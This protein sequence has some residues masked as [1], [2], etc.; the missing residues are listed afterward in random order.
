MKVAVVVLNWNG[1]H[2][3]HECLPALYRQ[4]RPPDQ[5]IVVDN[6]STDDSVA[7]LHS[8]YPQVE[9]VALKENRGFAG[10]NAVALRHVRGDAVV[11]LNNDTRP[12]DNFVEALV[13]CAEKHPEAG[14]IA[15]HLVDWDGKFT[16]S[17]G[18]GCKV[19][20]RGFARNRRKDAASAPA[21][22]RV[23]CACAGA[24]LYR[25]EMIEQIG[26]L[27]TD[28][29]LNFEDTDLALRACLQ[30]WESWFCAEA[31][32]R[33][34]I[35]ASQGAW[36]R[37]NVYYGAR[38][39]LWVCFKNFPAAVL[40]KYSPLIAAEIL[41]MYLVSV[42]HGRG[43]SYI[44][45]LV[46]GFRGIPRLLR[47]RREIQRCRSISARQ[48]ETGLTPISLKAAVTALFK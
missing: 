42:R 14:S 8:E 18:D 6:A 45:G 12:H 9:V 39:H 17:A 38:N 34:R 10:G 36:S 7:W 2:H 25:M 46:D 11:L 40:A 3:L 1:L 29:F 31:V 13:A 27:D 43:L 47:K 30:G 35:S 41:G 26:F 4:T 21:T 44:K 24:A 33:H 23:L 20:G 48:F 15:A 5:I 16:D 37:V 22:G 28:F 19:T 32:V